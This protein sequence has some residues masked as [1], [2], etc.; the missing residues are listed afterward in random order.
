VAA[1]PHAAS[2]VVSSG[3]RLRPRSRDGYRNLLLEPP[4][5]PGRGEFWRHRPGASREDAAGLS[6]VALHDGMG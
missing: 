5:L 2:V 3:L 6:V 1:G 4:L